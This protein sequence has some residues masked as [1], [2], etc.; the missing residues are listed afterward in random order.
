MPRTHKPR[1]GSVQY[2]PRKRAKRIYPRIRTWPALA[3]AKPA[4]FAGYKAG[5]THVTVL[6]E[7]KHSLYRGEEVV[8]PVTVV[9][10]PP[11][12]IAGLRFYKQGN[13]AKE[14]W[15]R[16]DKNLSRKVKQKATTFKEKDLS[17]FDD[18]KLIVHTQPHLTGI[19][20]KKPEVFEIGIGGSLQEK[21]EFALIKEEVRVKDVFKEGQFLDV[22]SITKGKG[23]QGP[24][25]RFGI[26]LKSHKSEK[27]RRRPGTLGGWK[28]Q[29]HFMYRL[30]MAGQAGFH[31]RVQLNAQIIRIGDKPEEVNVKGGFVNYGL[32]RNDYLLLKG[33]V[34]GPKKRLL[35]LRKALRAEEAE[36]LPI[37]HVSASSKQGR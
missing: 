36:L 32:L 4:G 16:F 8:I 10:C 24:V 13:P 5:M 29:Q 7:R 22:F 33:S 27:G 37:K 12:K 23:T 34:P 21:T 26:S 17:A 31:Q 19:G 2:W 11:L 20:K 3:E 18:A 35:V 14:V 30:A 1:S 6:D 9:E 25:K 28:A 15:L